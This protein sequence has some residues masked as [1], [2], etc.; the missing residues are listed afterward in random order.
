MAE[1]ITNLKSQPLL[2]TKACRLM[3]LNNLN[4]RIMSLAM[5]NLR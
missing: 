4:R 2:K 1:P 3:V 5:R